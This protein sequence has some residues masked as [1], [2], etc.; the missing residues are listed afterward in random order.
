MS[1]AWTP[2]PPARISAAEWRMLAV[3]LIPIGGV[4]LFDWT[5]LS[6]VMLYWAETALIVGYNLLRL[7]LA[8][9][10]TPPEDGEEPLPWRSGARSGAANT[11]T[12]FFLLWY[13]L[14]LYFSGGVIAGLFDLQGEI[15]PGGALAVGRYVLVELWPA[16]AALLV[17]YALNFR[18]S[19]LQPLARGGEGLFTGDTA[20]LYA[21]I[22]MVR[23]LIMGAVV[24]LGGGFCLLGGSALPLVVLVGFKIGLDLWLYNRWGP[25]RQVDSG[26]PGGT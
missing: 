23:L 22:P 2:A 9:R 13:G 6:V 1:E 15:G 20:N 17:D 11:L 10:V 14:V 19:F 24:F 7:N 5:L 4:L 12:A 25:G 3:N 8:Y 16:L 26:S 21:L 18:A